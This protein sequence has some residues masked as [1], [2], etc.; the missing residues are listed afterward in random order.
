MFSKQLFDQ[1]KDKFKKFLSVSAQFDEGYKWSAL[2]S[3][4]EHWN[5]G[6]T[7]FA[8]MYDRSVQQGEGE[9]L[10]SEKNDY[11]KSVMIEFAKMSPEITRDIFDDLFK[12]S[13]DVVLR[14]NRFVH[15][16][17]QML[18]DLQKTRPSANIHFHDNYKMI[19]HYLAMK[20]PHKYTFFDYVSFKALL[21]KLGA[22]T[23]PG[24]REIE[25]YFKLTNIFQKF[26]MQD[27]ELVEVYKK[28]LEES[29]TTPEL[30][31]FFAHDF[32]TCCTDAKYGLDNY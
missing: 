4:E 9:R 10:W 11:A 30:N 8:S 25:R 18:A 29:G 26:L 27:E 24:S 22:K 17:D 31:L 16:C 15:H 13:S 7:D 1:Y 20:D 19:S 2:G 21:V 14:M 28:K 5:I 3:W 12:E 6:A 23:V 32:M